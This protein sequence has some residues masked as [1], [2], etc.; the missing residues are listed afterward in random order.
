MKLAWTTGLLYSLAAGTGMANEVIPEPVQ[1][2]VQEAKVV[3][4]ARYSYL[5]W[6]IYDA[7]LFASQGKWL[8][9]RP[10]ALSLTYLRDFDGSDIASRSIKE[11]REQGLDNAELHSRWLQ[12]MEALFPDVVAQD[13]IVGLVTENRVTRFYHNGEWLGDV[14][15]PAFATWFFNIWLGPNTSEPEFRAELLQQE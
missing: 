15:D 6:D 5:F 1:A 12:Q 9:D 4:K 13:T 11:M 8:A 14:E 7:H 3:G 2:V 10:F